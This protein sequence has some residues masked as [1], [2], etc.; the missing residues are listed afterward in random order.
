MMQTHDIL[1]MD[2][3]EET[4]TLN[5]PSA[6][7]VWS[8]PYSFHAAA[9]KSGG[10]MYVIVNKGGKPI[11]VGQT[12]SYR[13]RFRSRIVSLRQAACDLSLSSVY[14]GSIQLP[15]GGA[16]NSRLRLDLESVLI[17]SYLKRGHK[18]TN[19][20][21]VLEFMMGQ[22]D[23][24]IYNKGTLPP[25][26]EI[27]IILK[28]NERFELDF[29]DGMDQFSEF[30]REMFAPGEEEIRRRRQLQ[31]RKSQPGKSRPPRPS[32]P[33]RPKPRFGRQ[34]LRRRFPP[35]RPQIIRRPAAVIR[36][37]QPC[38]T[39]QQ[40]SEYVRWVQSSLNQIQG[41]ALSINGVMNRATRE[42]LK[43]FQ[44]RQ[45]LPVD[46]I[47]GPETK[48]AL[49]AVKSDPGQSPAANDAPSTE[50]EQFLGSL[51]GYTPRPRRKK[52]YS[53]RRQVR[54]SPA[55]QIQTTVDRNSREYIKWLQQSL[56]RVHGLNL[57]EDGILGPMTR[58]AIRSFQS[59]NGLAVDGI[60]GP[61][62]ENAL[63]AAG[64]PRPTGRSG[65]YIP[66]SPVSVQPG[67]PP[68]R[69]T[70]ALRFITIS[71]SVI[72][73]PLI[74]QVVKELDGYFGKANLKVTLTSAVRTPE[75]QLGIIKR[76]AARYGID[77]KYPSIKTATVDNVES[78]L[79]S[80]DELLNYKKYIVNPPKPVTSRISGRYIGISPHMKGQAIDLSGANLDSIAAVVRTYCQQGGA[81]SQIL[82]ERSNNAVHVGIGTRGDCGITVK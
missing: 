33:F 11:Y 24:L 77:Q 7:I 46:G 40:G 30:E 49:I 57:A 52:T 81:V 31:R 16:Q 15:R 51:W 58:S 80:W 56:N 19:R 72:T 74:D 36:Q 64:A 71:S 5:I 22:K 27:R 54:S 70:G 26:M 3:E 55:P 78:W 35:R 63:I 4:R 37:D 44:N 61:Q 68:G 13:S 60:V 14:L 2:E 82:I 75:A 73:N 6:T 42:A 29:E 23:A 66:T 41:V 18:L 12:G 17:R 39:P 8:G 38:I 45:G 47:A 43:D 20:S 50:Q 62:T 69:Q 34:G 32:F 67:Q 79:D 48:Q 1:I 65:S 59:Q 28:R 76:A 53:N 10:G 25:H 21:S 9:A